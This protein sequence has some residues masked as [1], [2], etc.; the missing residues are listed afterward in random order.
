M[1]AFRTRN[2]QFGLMLATAL[3]VSLWP[4]AGRA[5]TDD[6]QQACMGDA[7]AALKFPMSSASGSA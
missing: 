7:S 1:F 2:F 6:Q 5:Y 3:L 4:A